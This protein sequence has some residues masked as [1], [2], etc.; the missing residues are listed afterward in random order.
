MES[1]VK[2]YQQRFR[3]VREEMDRWEQLQSRLI[4]LF[5]N[6]S[7][8]IERL[9]VVQNPK[10]YD[11]CDIR[12]AVL[13]K[14]LDSLQAILVSISRTL[15]GLHGVVLFLEKM[16]NDGSQF[17][18]GGSD[19][20]TTKQLQ[21][22]VGIKPCL[23]DCLNG[24]MLLYEMHRSEYLLKLSLSSALSTLALRPTSSDLSAL[25]QL[26]VDQPNIPKEEVQSIFDT[27]FAEE[28]C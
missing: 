12:D 8:I 18:R 26:L 1:L 28:I 22:R 4:S 10:N 16:Y 24:L 25:H 19:Q 11:S 20:L 27:I 15:E 5:Q 21:Q 3:K 7:S 6:A 17:A 2:K 13:R 9:Q 14:Q 23:Q